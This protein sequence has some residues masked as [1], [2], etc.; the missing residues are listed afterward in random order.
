[1]HPLYSNPFSWLS[2]RSQKTSL[3]VFGIITVFLFIILNIIDQPLRNIHAPDGIVSFELAG[4]YIQT[5]KIINSWNQLTKL[6]AALSLGIDYLFLVAYSLFFSLSIFKISEN[7]AGRK[8]W[9]SRIGLN[10]AWSQFLAAIFDA[11]E[12]YSLIRLLFGSQNKI[13][14]SLAFY[15]ASMKF[16]LISSGAIYIAMGLILSFALRIRFSK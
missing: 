9:L 16:F 15:F 12:N 4:N 8:E 11:V 6:F 13:F 2:A 10:L 3:W 1:M 5:Q 14:S 7:Y